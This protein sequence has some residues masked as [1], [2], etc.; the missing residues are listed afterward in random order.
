VRHLILSI[1]PT[2]IPL[3]IALCPLRALKCYAML[4]PMD[5]VLRFKFEQIA[6]LAE[7][8]NDGNSARVAEDYIEQVIVPKVS[9]DGY[10]E[11]E[12]FL[13]ICYWKTPR[14]QGRCSQNGPPFVREVTTIAL[15]TANEQLR[16]EVLTL[17][18]GVGWPTASVF[19]H[20]GHKEQ[21]P[22]LDFRA[23]ESLSIEQ[24]TDY[25]FAFWEGYV[26][27]CRGLAKEAGV[28]MRILDRALW[29]YSAE[30]PSPKERENQR[31]VIKR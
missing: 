31:R 30:N 12:D 6:E 14:T 1:Y 28:T 18:Q 22:I 3:L 2:K 29:Q 11:Y 20:F 8:Y 13:K 7:R 5:Y 17:L 25:T 27:I 9:R 15:G 10:F 21:Y 4:D 16:V 26:R 23:L 24:P 19:L